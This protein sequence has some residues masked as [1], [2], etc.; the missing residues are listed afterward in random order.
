[1]CVDVRAPRVQAEM[2]A[3]LPSGPVG[4]EPLGRRMERQQMHQRVHEVA[5][6]VLEHSDP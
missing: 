5:A 6:F 2:V 4:R 1:M 3:D